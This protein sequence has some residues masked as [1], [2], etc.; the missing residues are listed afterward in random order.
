MVVSVKSGEFKADPTA[1]RT[2]PNLTG[3]ESRV[4]E[5]KDVP[6]PPMPLAVDDLPPT[7]VI[8]SVVKKDDKLVVSGFTA[9][10]G[11]LKR[12]TV[13]GIEAKMVDAGFGAWEA[14][15]D[16]ATDAKAFAEDAAGNV[17]KTPAVVRVK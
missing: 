4:A 13:N 2:E 16:A 14:T 8:T 11:A 7:T 1:F 3:N 17:E 15:V 9:D 12:V 6:F 10:N 5:V